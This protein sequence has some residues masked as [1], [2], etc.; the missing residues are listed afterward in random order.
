M[1]AEEKDAK[2]NVNNV[3]MDMFF[4]LPVTINKQRKDANVTYERQIASEIHA[5]TFKK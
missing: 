3:T 1:E 4:K 2:R 5:K